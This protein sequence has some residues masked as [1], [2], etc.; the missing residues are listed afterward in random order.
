MISKHL[1]ESQVWVWLQTLFHV[2]TDILIHCIVSVQFILAVAS[3]SELLRVFDLGRSAG[4]STFMQLHD[5]Y[6]VSRPWRYNQLFV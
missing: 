4:H 3:V 5:D 1:G 2:P 6:K